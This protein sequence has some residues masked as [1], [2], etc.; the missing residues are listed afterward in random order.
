MHTHG[1]GQ[2]NCVQKNCGRAQAVGSYQPGS[3]H[4][5]SA[6]DQGGKSNQSTKSVGSR[7]ELACEATARQGVLIAQQAGERGDWTQ[8]EALAVRRAAALTAAAAAA[9]ALAAVLCSCRLCCSP[10]NAAWWQRCGVAQPLSRPAGS[11]GCWRSACCRIRAD[12][13]RQPCSGRCRRC[14]PGGH[15]PAA[16]MQ[17]PRNWRHKG[18][19]GS[20]GG[21]G[22]R[23]VPAVIRRRPAE[24]VPRQL[25][26]ELLL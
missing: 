25:L 9:S 1:L 12:W 13:C 18:A 6:C 10:G 4:G 7:T 11:S 15:I 14:Q 8:V 17:H 5:A 23:A 21:G 2:T 24:T 26:R 16:G 22:G 20:G 19:T 3:R